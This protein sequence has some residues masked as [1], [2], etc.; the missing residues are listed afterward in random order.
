MEADITLTNPKDIEYV[1]GKIQDIV[2]SMLR[3]AA[4]RELIK[5]TCTELK[6]K[7]EIP[8]PVSR[9]VA[10]FIVNEDK[11]GKAE[12]ELDLVDYLIQLTKD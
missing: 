4:E 9:K 8:T 3:I 2:D 12:E 7:H 10:T 1:I 11:Q 5:D 6:E